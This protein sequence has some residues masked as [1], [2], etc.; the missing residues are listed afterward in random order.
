MVENRIRLYWAWGESYLGGRGRD[1]KACMDYKVSSRPA[2]FTTF[3]YLW[4]RGAH[5]E[6]KEQLAR[7]GR[8]PWHQAFAHCTTLP[9][10]ALVWDV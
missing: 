9:A 8:L 4:G 6:A 10:Q 7:V 1:F 2:I 3:I 5:S